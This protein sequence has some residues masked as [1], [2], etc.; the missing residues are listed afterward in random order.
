MPIPNQA[1]I[2]FF[3][4]YGGILSLVIGALSVFI[5]IIFFVFGM[6]TESRT[7]K[8]LAEIKTQ[9]DMLQQITAKQFD[10]LIDNNHSVVQSFVNHSTR[11]EQQKKQ[12]E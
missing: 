6:K 9:T 1:L 4:V 5:S 10:K 7:R 3:N 11:Q 8:V 12:D 2:D